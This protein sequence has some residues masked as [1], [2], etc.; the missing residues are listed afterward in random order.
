MQ[1]RARYGSAEDADLHLVISHR[2][3]RN[4]SLEKQARAAKGKTCVEVPAGYD[5]AYK[6][7][8]GTGSATGRG[9]LNGARYIVGKIESQQ[10]L[11]KDELTECVN[12]RGLQSSKV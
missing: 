12:I 11:L 6:R 1:V 5:P 2:R 7:F 10:I 9:F 3:R 8:V 4:N